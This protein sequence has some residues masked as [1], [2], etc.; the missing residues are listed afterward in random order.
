[1]L[2]GAF[3]V[4][5]A[6]SRTP[7]GAG[8]TG[9]ARESGIPKATVHRLLEQLVELGA[10][11]RDGPRYF[12]GDTLA[13]IGRS[14]QPRPALRRATLAPTRLLARLTSSVATV[15]MI[16]GG[17]IRVVATAG[18]LPRPLPQVRVDDEF[19]SRTAAGRILLASGPQH[20]VPTGFS[21]TEWRRAR[22]TLTRR[23]AVCVDNEEVMPG[24]H[25]AAA[26]IALPSGETACMTVI[27]V[28]RRP[29]ANLGDLVLRAVRDTTLNLARDVAGP[30]R[31]S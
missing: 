13:E 9:I 30:E 6:L 4:L 14:W 3:E 23:D 29:P 24:T 27:M 1:V 25:C 28:G 20:D 16:H 15:T 5:H 22:E 12:V 11:Q 31:H 2:E 26:A 8:L 7:E 18:R 10:A 19:S 21:R 17:A